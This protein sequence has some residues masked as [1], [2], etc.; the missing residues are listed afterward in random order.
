MKNNTNEDED[1]RS[2]VIPDVIS[3]SADNLEM[4]VIDETQTSRN[5]VH[6]MKEGVI[7]DQTQENEPDSQ[8]HFKQISSGVW[9]METTQTTVN[10]SIDVNFF[11]CVHLL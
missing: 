2:E 8:S 4:K 5:V 10:Q 1:E 7:A 11:D 9:G 6:V 3:Q